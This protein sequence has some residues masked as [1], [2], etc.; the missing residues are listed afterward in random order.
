M[1]QVVCVKHVALWLSAPKAA[2]PT[3]PS[4]LRAFKTLSVRWECKMLLLSPVSLS[5]SEG[6]A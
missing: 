1:G 4:P 5:C 3:V 6:A 2:S